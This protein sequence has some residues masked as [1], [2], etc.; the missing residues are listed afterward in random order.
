M[1]VA[2]NMGWYSHV[3]HEMHDT[4]KHVISF[5][6]FALAVKLECVTP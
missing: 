2:V 1:H 4:T 5:S 6:F 3:R